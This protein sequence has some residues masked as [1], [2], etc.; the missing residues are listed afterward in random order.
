MML[1]MSSPRQHKTR[2]ITLKQTQHHT[3]IQ[4]HSSIENHSVLPFKT[5]P[6]LWSCCNFPLRLKLSG[7]FIWAEAEWGTLSGNRC[8]GCLMWA[9]G[10]P[11][12]LRTRSNRD[13]ILAARDTLSP[14]LLPFWWS[15]QVPKIHAAVLNKTSDTVTPWLMAGQKEPPWGRTGLGLA[16]STYTQLITRVNEKVSAESAA[17]TRLGLVCC[18]LG[19]SDCG[20]ESDSAPNTVVIQAFSF[21][22]VA[23]CLE[24]RGNEK[25]SVSC[26]LKGTWHSRLSHLDMYFVLALKK[27][28]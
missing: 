16:A 13:P 2:R 5:T 26:L 24:L 3:E 8:S 9:R 4:K 11:A 19:G 14:L 20:A 27:H 12:G 21:C 7:P 6:R 1:L 28:L 15:S 10:G 17:E 25:G 23:E 18:S 22:S